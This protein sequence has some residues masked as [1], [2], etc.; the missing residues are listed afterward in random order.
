[1]S[2][3]ICWAS[4]RGERPSRESPLSS[5]PISPSTGNNGSGIGGD[6]LIEPAGHFKSIKDCALVIIP[7]SPTVFVSDTIYFRNIYLI[8]SNVPFL[9]Q[10]CLLCKPPEIDRMMRSKYRSKGIVHDTTS[11]YLGV[12]FLLL[13]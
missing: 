8:L 3:T 5:Y 11:E 2:D 13:Q 1:M 12:V 9:Q 10:F 6:Q 4:S 7:S